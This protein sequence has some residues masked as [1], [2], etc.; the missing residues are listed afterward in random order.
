MGEARQISR[1]LTKVVG[2]DLSAPEPDCGARGPENTEVAVDEETTRCWTQG[3]R[4]SIVPAH[5]KREL[6]DGVG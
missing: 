1:A 3:G 6:E 5:S 4:I 2:V